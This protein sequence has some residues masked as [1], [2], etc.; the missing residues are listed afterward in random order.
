MTDLQLPHAD[1]CDLAGPLAHFAEHGWARLGRVAEDRTLDA[2]RERVDDLMLG[3]ITYPGLFFQMDAPTGRYDDLTFGKG[4]EGPSL[5][6]RK[7]EKVEKDPLFRAWI[8]APLFERIA[9][10]LVPGAE[11]GVAIYRAVIF[12]K[13]ATG[14]SDLPWH[15]DGGRFWGLDRE[16]VLQ[17]WTVLDDAPENGGCV[18]VLDGSH[19][20]GLASPLGGVIQPPLL[21]AQRANER[22]LR[23][24]ARAGEVLL[25]HNHVWHRSARN[26]TG[27]PRRA[28][29]VCYMSAG[30]RCLRTK[31]APRE[32]VRIFG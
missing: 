18:E 24:P 25:L 3:R 7:L 22:A 19:L 16:P 13:G 9:R 15:Q 14:G 23:I 32:F 12:A 2:L 10:A 21:E 29:T 5:G 17:I 1:A 31:R 11:E 8:A 27:R 20:A 26:Q 28:L 4:W 6:Y 30:T